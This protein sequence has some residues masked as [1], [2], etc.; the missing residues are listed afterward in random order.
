MMHRVNIRTESAARASFFTIVTKC[1]H[2]DIEKYRPDWITPQI[3]THCNAPTKDDRDFA[4][5]LALAKIV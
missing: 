1:V 2:I 5:M 4:E 3:Q